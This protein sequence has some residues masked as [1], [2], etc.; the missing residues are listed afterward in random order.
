MGGVDV[1]DQQISYYQPNFHCRR[2][3]LPMFIQCLSMIRNNYYIV[4]QHYYGK[5]NCMTLKNFT[6][7]MI[8]DLVEKAS[9]LTARWHTRIP[10]SPRLPPLQNESNK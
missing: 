9:A 7:S 8:E 4:H 1:L 3:W 6:L 5:K 2:I 10:M